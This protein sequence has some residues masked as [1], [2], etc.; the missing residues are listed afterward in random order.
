MSAANPVIA[1]SSTNTW[2][3]GLSWG[4]SW[5]AP[6]A[7]TTVIY[8]AIAANET[9]DFGGDPVH[10]FQPYAEETAAIQ[11]VL[12]SV[13]NIVN[14]DFVATTD[15]SVADIVFASVSDADA[16]G[17]LGVSLPP[18]EYFNQSIGDW[19]SVVISNREAYHM[20]G[21]TPD[22]L[23]PGGFDYITWLHEFGHDL[24]LAHPHDNGGTSTIFPGVSSPFNSYGSYFM[25]QGIFTTM[26]YNDGWVAGPGA[27][28]GSGVAQYG[29]QATMMAL[30][31]ATLQLLYGANTSFA[32]GDNS[33]ALGDENTGG[34]C[35]QCIW[36]TGGLDTLAYD[37]SRNATLDLR[38]ASLATATGGGG[39]MS[40]VTSGGIVY[41]AFTIAAGV[42]IENASGGGG[43]DQ[44]IGNAADNL[45]DG[46][47]GTDTMTGGKGNDTYIV[48]QAL[49][50]VVELANEG[51]DTV[52][53]AIDWV[54]GLNVENL[55]LEDAASI[56][57]GNS[58]ANTLYG[59]AGANIL[60][61]KAGADL[62][63]GLDGNDTYIVDSTADQIF[64]DDGEGTDQV[65]AAVSF[66]LGA[67]V[68]NLLLTGSSKINA[69]G[70]DDGNSLTGNG[71]T[72]S[73]DGKLGADI[74]TGGAGKDNFVFST[75]LG[76]DNIDN[77]TDYSAPQD[78]ICLEHDIF[79]SLN[80]GKLASTAFHIGSAAV[81]ANDF[82]IYDKATGALY[83]DADGNGAGEAQQF[84]QLGAGLNL[85]N[86]DFFTF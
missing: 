38:A 2:I 30:D 16:G 26:T 25:N 54:L 67:H 15:L 83:Y 17:N 43:N 40:Y 50:K 29:Y 34:A 79:T 76:P 28:G 69:T 6:G 12:Q 47:V 36:D 35:Y 41:S 42:V 56:A 81:D 9:V 23:S 1:P 37:G 27:R 39:F 58:L 48:G 18:G 24:G 46:G 13:E 71:K 62:L 7:G 52:V 65:N 49:D 68:E 44:L 59:T 14:V 45:L 73:L 74:L 11:N 85:T 31:V 10:A 63:H 84:A 64:E 77:I 53:A 80:F 5:D 32:N 86:S 55:H 78:T 8:Y 3:R 4:T 72:N 20:N 22:G 51:V 75:L 70:N 33:Y 60:D 19:Q 61:G 21:A 66:T 82:I 57:T